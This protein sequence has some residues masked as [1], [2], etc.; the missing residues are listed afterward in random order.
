VASTGTIALVAGGGNTNPHTSVVDVSNPAL[1]VEVAT[2]PSV[3]EGAIS[4]YGHYALLPQRA[5]GLA[6]V[7][8]S[9]PSIPRTK[10]LVKTPG[11]IY[12]AVN[13]NGMVYCGDTAALVDIIDLVP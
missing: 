8:L 13:V 1:P 6:V 9:V 4:T 11:S 5:L 12:S 2:I 10:T 3:P 7:D